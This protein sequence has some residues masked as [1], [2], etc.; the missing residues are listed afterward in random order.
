MSRPTI[1]SNTLTNGVSSVINAIITVVLT[2]ILISKLGSE[3]YGLWSLLLSA[4]YTYGYLAIGDLGLGEYMLRS[5]PATDREVPNEQK[6]LAYVTSNSLVAS[7]IGGLL[8]IAIAS[9]VIFLISRLGVS[10]SFDSRVLFLCISLILCEAF[11]EIICSIFRGFIEGQ[12]RFK[13]ARSI[14]TSG[15]IIWGI[16]ASLILFNGGGVVQLALATALISLTRLSSY[17]FCSRLVN[18]PMI[19]SRSLISYNGILAVVKGGIHLN[20]LRALYSIYS[21]MDRSIIAVFLTVAAITTY[22]ISFRF[23]SVTVLLLATSSSAIIPVISKQHSLGDFGANKAVLL[24]GTSITVTI[25]IPICLGMFLYAPSIIEIWVGPGHSAAVMPAR[26][27]LLFPMLSSA[28]QIGIAM[29]T[30]VGLTRNVL[31]YQAISVFI[32]LILSIAFVKLFGL[33]GVV[34]GTL[35]SNGFLW[36]PYSKLILTTFNKSLNEWL[37]IILIPTLVAGTIQ[38]SLFIASHFLLHLRHSYS[39]L[40]CGVATLIALASSYLIANQSSHFFNKV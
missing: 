27:F 2:P 3:N 26:I 18:Q 40:A 22:D 20:G 1:F 30:A 7:F 23:F 34:L 9:A 32:N 28:N 35:I 29:L 13:I 6:S 10:N 19:F 14:D 24:K 31:K 36:I 38:G 17:I 15:R 39:V 4:S 37:K 21:Q 8:S 33:T 5:V 25:M 16:S 11:F 12:G